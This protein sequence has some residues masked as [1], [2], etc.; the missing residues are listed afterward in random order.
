MKVQNLMDLTLP[1]IN[2]LFYGQS[3]TITDHN[4]GTKLYFKASDPT[5]YT[6]IL[7][8]RMHHKVLYKGKPL[9][10][11]DVLLNKNLEE[12]LHTA[13]KSHMVNNCDYVAVLTVAGVIIEE[14]IRASKGSGTKITIN[15]QFST[16]Q[17]VR[18]FFKRFIN[19]SCG[20]IINC[21]NSVLLYDVQRPQRHSAF[22]DSYYFFIK[23]LLLN[24]DYLL[25]NYSYR[26]TNEDSSSDALSVVLFYASLTN[27]LIRQFY[28]DKEAE[29]SYILQGFNNQVNHSVISGL[30]MLDSDTA[31]NRCVLC[32]VLNLFLKNRKFNFL[33]SIITEYDRQLYATIRVKLDK[34][35]D[36]H[37]V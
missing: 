8:Y 18:T 37:I 23:R 31:V 33:N 5:H 16:K 14:P 34:I 36:F 12:I 11:V 3:V 10:L 30:S 15:K 9:Q 35:L 21:N 6:S 29:L 20:I 32:T 27:E 24:V 28:M 7:R 19:N 2:S 1:E 25:S 4:V 17:T 22:D 13:S 26:I